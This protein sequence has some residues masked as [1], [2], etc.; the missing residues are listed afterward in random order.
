MSEKGYFC[1]LN[2]PK[3]SSSITDFEKKHTPVIECPDTV[4][5]DQP[6][7]VRFKLGEIPHVT[8]EGHFIQWAEV[9]F[10]ENLY[11][12]VEFS[13]VM[14]LPEAT[15]ALSKGSR[16]GKGTLRVLAK[17]NLHGL[18]EATKEITITAD[19]QG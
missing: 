1:G 12:R 16:H 19:Q 5:A 17:C 14:S 18:W 6:F 13:P 15:V 3:D 9:K 8:E 2:R 7:H 11:V 4:V 10:G